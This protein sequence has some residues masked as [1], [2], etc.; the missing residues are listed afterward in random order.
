[1]PEYSLRAVILNLLIAF[2]E[3]AKVSYIRRLLNTSR[4]ELDD[5]LYHMDKDRDIIV[6]GQQRSKK[7]RIPG[8]SKLDKAQNLWLYRRT[9]NKRTTRSMNS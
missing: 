4:R 6:E 2:P 3:G 7:I 8:L 5:L 1:M 9:I